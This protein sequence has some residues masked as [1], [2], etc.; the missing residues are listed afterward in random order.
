[1][2]AH[3]NW[4]SAFEARIAKFEG[5]LATVKWVSGST[6]AIVLAV[7]GLMMPLALQ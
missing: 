6:L 3:G 4:L 5:E 7:L 1:M 2:I